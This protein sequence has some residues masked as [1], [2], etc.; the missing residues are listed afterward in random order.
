MTRRLLA[1]LAVTLLCSSCTQ[2]HGVSLGSA[3]AKP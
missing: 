3:A 2:T 1:W